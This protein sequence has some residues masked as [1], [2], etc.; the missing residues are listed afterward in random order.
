MHDL[1]HG[2]KTLMLNQLNY[3]WH[4]SSLI[5]P[6]PTPTESSTKKQA[7]YYS[8]KII[9]NDRVSHYLHYL[10]NLPC[11]ICDYLAQYTCYKF[12]ALSDN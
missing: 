7:G 10:F 11:V 3:F 1:S 8:V 9:R 6:F 4:E 2:N 12:V 5:L